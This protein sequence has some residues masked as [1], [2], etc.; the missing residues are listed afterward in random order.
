MSPGDDIVNQKPVLGARVYPRHVEVIWKAE[1]CVSGEQVM[2]GTC[3]QEKQTIAV[4]FAYSVMPYN[5]YPRLHGL[6]STFAL[7]FPSTRTLIDL[8]TAE[9]RESSSSQNLSLA[10]S[11]LVM[12]E[13]IGTDQHGF[14]FIPQRELQGYQTIVETFWEASEF[15]GSIDFDGQAFISFAVLVTFAST[16]ENV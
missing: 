1:D 10:S 11:G 13:T 14:A 15:L 12:V 5:S 4:T 8:D 16:S 9:I 3:F 6:F 2:H 7:K